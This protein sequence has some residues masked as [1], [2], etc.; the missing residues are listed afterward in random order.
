MLRR[1]ELALLSAMKHLFTI[2]VFL[3]VRKSKTHF[4]GQQLICTSTDWRQIGHKHLISV[5][6]SQ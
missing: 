6:Y 2:I 4:F 5:T 3:K 1:N